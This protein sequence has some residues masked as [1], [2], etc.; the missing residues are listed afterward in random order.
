MS[1][2]LRL[3]RAPVCRITRSTSTCI[4]ARLFSTQPSVEH[5]RVPCASSGDITVSLHNVSKHDAVTPLV[6]FIPPFSQ[7]S[8]SITAPLPSCFADYPT[9]IIHYRWQA[10]ERD[11][12]PEIPLHWPTPLHDVSFGYSWIA[13]NL[14]SGSNG[15]AAPRPAYVYGSYLGASLAAGLALTESH[16]PVRS[17]PMTIRGL[18]AHNGIYNWTMFLPDHPIHKLKIRLGVPFVNVDDSPVP[19]DEEGIFTELKHQAPALFSDPSNLFDPFAS[20][21]L[22]FHSADLHVPDDFTT[23]LFPPSSSLSAEFTAA[24]DALAGSSSSSSS[25]PFPSLDAN[26]P[27]SAPEE[28]EES[29]ESLLSK[30]ATLAK[31]SNLPRKGYLVFPPRDSTLRL[32]PTLFLYDR[33]REYSSYSSSPHSSSHSPQSP[34]FAGRQLRRR[35]ER[36]STSQ[37]NF[38]VQA[39][40]LIGLM[41][42]SLDMH[43][44]RRRRP[45][46]WEWEADPGSSS[47]TAGDEEDARM[48]EIERRV[49]SCELSSSSSSF[50]SL[51]SLMMVDKEGTGL[52]LQLLGKEGEEMVAEWLRERIDEDFG[53]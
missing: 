43:E 44:L 5:V 18:V 4:Q 47:S 49:Q 26:N 29:A 22:F 10:H 40:E 9:A 13:A 6:I 17:L 24:V 52:G 12:R 48:R 32:P 23:P 36:T 3:L 38:R 33:P 25:S 19:F 8:P 1:R 35:R 39:M 15:S 50:P 42:R 34:F 51:E 53:E 2:W 31:Q 21:C 37:N 20:A 27:G 41:M 16:V 45:A 7:P 30:A 11:H 46:P 14:G 28:E